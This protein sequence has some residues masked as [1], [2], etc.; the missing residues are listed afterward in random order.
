MRIVVVDPSRTVL[1]IVSRLLEA[2]N[3]EVHP[4]TDGPEAL[5]HVKADIEVDAL[6]TSVELPSMTGMDICHE[7]RKLSVTRR[8]IYVVLMS[9]NFDQ[10]KLI[11]ALDSGADDFIGKPPATEELYARLRAAARLASMQR[12]LVRMA[13]TD[14]LSGALN[15]RAFFERAHDAASYAAAGETLSA[16]IFDIDHFKRVN[17][18]HGHDIG[19]EVIRLVSREVMAH[20]EPLGRLGGEE[21][22]ILMKGRGLKD[23]AIFAEKL[24]QNLAGLQIDAAGSIVTFTCSFGV[25]EWGGGDTVDTLLKR[26]D[27]ALY[28][29]KQTGRNRVCKADALEAMDES[30]ESAGI[31]RFAAR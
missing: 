29:A 15:R 17:D 25:S 1:K 27:I 6:I 26:A 11:E 14:Y 21:F 19:D 8:P 22:A 9:S 2:G 18:L 13:T 28:K 30:A 10:K 12:E 7:V 4:F 24:R 23:A 20:G 5:A 16:L 3:H 31:I